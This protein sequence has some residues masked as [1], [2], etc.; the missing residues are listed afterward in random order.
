MYFAFIIYQSYVT[1]LAIL[2]F[3]GIQEMIKA[4]FYN[5]SKHARLDTPWYVYILKTFQFLFPS[6][7]VFP[8][9]WTYNIIP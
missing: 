5:L 9:L 1:A 4:G 2:F 8:E 3:W 7:S 6:F